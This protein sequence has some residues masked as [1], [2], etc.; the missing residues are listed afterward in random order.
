MWKLLTIRS[1]KK[2]IKKKRKSAVQKN[3]F[4]F[5]LN[6]KYSVIVL[7]RR[8]HY[9]VKNALCIFVCWISK[10]KDTQM[11]KPTIFTVLFSLVHSM[12]YHLNYYEPETTKI[13]SERITQIIFKCVVPSC[14]RDT[15]LL[16]LTH[17]QPMIDQ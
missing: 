1:L 2:L 9:V 17:T 15:H 11:K 13:L 10:K 14:F 8:K 4:L 12:I 3:S 16:M 6:I 7:V 5:L